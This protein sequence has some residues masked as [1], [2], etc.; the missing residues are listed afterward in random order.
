MTNEKIALTK[1]ERAFTI[2]RI[3]EDIALLRED[4]GLSLEE[5]TISTDDLIIDILDVLNKWI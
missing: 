5:N 4:K 1:E 3:L 2:N